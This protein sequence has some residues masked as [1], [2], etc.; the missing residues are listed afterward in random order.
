[1]K[2]WLA[3]WA[4]S[5]HQPNLRRLQRINDLRLYSNLCWQFRR[6]LPHEQA[7]ASARG[8]AAIID[9]LWLRGALSGDTF[10]TQQALQIAYDYLDL[11]LAK[12]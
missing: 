4:T 10:N 7:R 8:L 11:Q 6:L 9:G 5:M 1:M 2:T 3:F 12:A